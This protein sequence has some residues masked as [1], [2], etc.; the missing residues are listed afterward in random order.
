[1]VRCREAGSR[2]RVDPY[3]MFSNLQS[4]T[5]WIK[6]LMLFHWAILDLSFEAVFIRY[7]WCGNLILSYSIIISVLCVL[8]FWSIV[9]WLMFYSLQPIPYWLYKLHGLNINYNCEICGNYN[10][11]GPKA[12]QR[13]F[14]VC[15]FFFSFRNRQLS[16]GLLTDDKHPQNAEY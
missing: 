16:S 1:M 3:C 6:L 2:I 4:S 11:R 14:A 5:L 13:H 15:G 8:W 9:C 10:Y 7:R 12:F